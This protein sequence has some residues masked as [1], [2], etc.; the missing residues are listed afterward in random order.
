[1]SRNGG[2]RGRE[3]TSREKDELDSLDR[4]SYWPTVSYYL[5]VRF[6]CSVQWQRKVV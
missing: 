4:V 3:E 5:R 2:C 1:M 6:R